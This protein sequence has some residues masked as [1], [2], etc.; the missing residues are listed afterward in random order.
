MKSENLREARFG[1]TDLGFK[2]K[3]LECFV[4]CKND[5]KIKNIIK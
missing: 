2:I 5:I 1:Y 4:N 3:H